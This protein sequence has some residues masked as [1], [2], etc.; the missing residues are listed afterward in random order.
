MSKSHYFFL[1]GILCAALLE[2]R[3]CISLENFSLVL[4]LK[5]NIQFELLILFLMSMILECLEN[6]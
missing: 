6:F 1:T 3:F 2:L 5:E 4:N